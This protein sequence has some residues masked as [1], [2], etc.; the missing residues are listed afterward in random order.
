VLEADRLRRA[1][2]GCAPQSRARVGKHQHRIAELVRPEAIA[3]QRTRCV[4][5]HPI[6]DECAQQFVM[7]APGFVRARDDRIDDV[8]VAAWW[9]I[10]SKGR[11]KEPH[12]WIDGYCVLINSNPR[13]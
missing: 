12:L 1:S 3:L 13:Q 11:W 5:Q 6:A 4:G 7:A 10:N 8:A 2:T 9:E